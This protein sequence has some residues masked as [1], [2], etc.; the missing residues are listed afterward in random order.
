MWELWQA[1]YVMTSA[2]LTRLAH[3][4]QLPW[5]APDTLPPLPGIGIDL[6]EF[7]HWAAL[8]R[9]PCLLNEVLLRTACS[10]R[11]LQLSMA[12]SAPRRDTSVL[13]DPVCHPSATPQHPG[14]SPATCGVLR[15][16]HVRGSVHRTA[17]CSPWPAAR[18]GAS[19]CRSSTW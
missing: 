6:A 11:I 4:G 5:T 15:R 13:P 3:A 17:M 16:A 9:A 2:N 10:K 14:H 12:G 8:V 19:C 1:D 7:G 18:L